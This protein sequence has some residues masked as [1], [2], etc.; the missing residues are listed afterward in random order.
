MKRDFLFSNIASKRASAKKKRANGRKQEEE[1][2]AGLRRFLLTEIK[3][4]L[5]T[6]TM[7]R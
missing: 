2:G 4:V 7:R 6:L 5:P 1:L 3:G